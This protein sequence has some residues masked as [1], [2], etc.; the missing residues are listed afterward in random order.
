MLKI[1]IEQISIP[2]CKVLTPIL[3]DLTEWEETGTMRGFKPDCNQA[4]QCRQ[5]LRGKA[6]LRGSEGAEP[7]PNG[8][9]RSQTGIGAHCH[10][11][12]FPL[13]STSY[14]HFSVAPF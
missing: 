11:S 3:S 9:A 12:R 2:F 14:H 5:V 6:G 13:T 8:G 10:D 1:L 7:A 4:V